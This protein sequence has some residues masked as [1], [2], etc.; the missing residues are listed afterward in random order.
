MA[1]RWKQLPTA[2]SNV[3][4]ANSKGADRQKIQMKALFLQGRE[5]S[6]WGRCSGGSCWL[7]TSGQLSCSWRSHGV[8]VRTGLNCWGDF[9]VVQP[10]TGTLL[11]FFMSL[12]LVT[13]ANLLAEPPIY[14]LISCWVGHGSILELQG[15]QHPSLGQHWFLPFTSHGLYSPSGLYKY[16]KMMHWCNWQVLPFIF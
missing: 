4:A 15:W 2:V 14:I 1:A 5:R 10:L 7:S 3:T 8:V 6:W 13:L 12:C 11:F 9:V 16:P